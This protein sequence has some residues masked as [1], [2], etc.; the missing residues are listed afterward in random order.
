M[1]KAFSLIELMV[2]IAIIAIVA[3]AALPAYRDYVIRAKISQAFDYMNKFKDQLVLHYQKHGAWPTSITFGNNT[4]TNGTYG[5]LQ[6]FV[7]K[8]NVAAL[9]YDTQLATNGVRI[10][11]WITGLD[12]IPGYV[13]PTG[14]G[15]FPKGGIRMSV[16]EKNGVLVMN[17]GQYNTGFPDLDLPDNYMPAV[18]TCNDVMGTL[19]NSPGV[20]NHG[21]VYQ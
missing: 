3:A 17:C 14:L 19:T 4:F 18:C 20:G 8:E 16:I 13:E 7:G 5:G 6:E 1:K 9:F 15:E 2:V 12:G 11:G 10:M 21:C